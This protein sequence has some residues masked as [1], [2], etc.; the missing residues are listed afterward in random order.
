[1]E[2]MGVVVQESLALLWQKKKSPLT[3]KKV[4]GWL[5][6]CTCHS[7]LILALSWLWET[8]LKD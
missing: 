7:C 6:R 8:T 5:I 3:F 4:L 2:V 1:M